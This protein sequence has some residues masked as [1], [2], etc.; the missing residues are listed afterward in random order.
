MRWIAARPSKPSWIVGQGG[1]ESM[2]LYVALLPSAPFSLD[3][4]AKENG[5]ICALDAQ[6]VGETSLLLGAGRQTKE[7]ILDMGAGVIL[8]KK[9]GDSVRRG[10]TVATLY[11][12]DEKKLANAK[13]CFLSAISYAENEPIMQPLIYKT[14]L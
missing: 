1:H 2:R 4:L 12:S 10:E 9:T 5:Y 8:H 14:V 13:E 11:A 6:R 7:D 3:T